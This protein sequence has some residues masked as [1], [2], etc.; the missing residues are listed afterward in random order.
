MGRPRTPRQIRQ[1]RPG[2]EREGEGGRDTAV[3]LR[4]GD[5]VLHR[6]VVVFAVL[7]N[8]G[9]IRGSLQNLRLGQ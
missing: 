1:A 8:L 6:R 5:N 2:E 3:S 7:K 9:D 4:A